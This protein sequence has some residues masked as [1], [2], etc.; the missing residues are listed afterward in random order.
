MLPSLEDGF[1]VIAYTEMPEY[2]SRQE[3]RRMNE[4]GRRFKREN[5]QAVRATVLHHLVHLL[6]L[7]YVYLG[8][9][10]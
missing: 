8:Y 9:L 3:V 2:D 1:T 4:E 5:P 6:A 7:Y 10:R